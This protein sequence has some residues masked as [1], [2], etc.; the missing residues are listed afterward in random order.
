[1][2]IPIPAGAA[3]ALAL[4]AACSSSPRVRSDWDQ[5]ADFAAYR[6]YGF[7]ERPGTDAAGYESLSTRYLKAACAR[8]L[9]ARGYQP[10]ES[11]DL[12]VDFWIQTADKVESRPSMSVGM[13][14]RH[15]PYGVYGSYPV[16]EVRTWT[17]GTVGIALVD[18]ARNQLVWEGVVAGR[19]TEKALAELETT[20]SDVA[21]EAFAHYPFR[22]GSGTPAEVPPGGSG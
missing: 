8:E 10:S 14:Y 3:L 7:V 6:T 22:A 5:A 1:M 16:E 15:G 19:V 11:P 9:E 21:R 4:T 2:K 20:L 18:A 17:E 13:G 12:L